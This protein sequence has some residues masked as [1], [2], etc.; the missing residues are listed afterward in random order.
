[1]CSFCRMSSHL[2]A[3]QTRSDLRAIRGPSLR[4]VTGEYDESEYAGLPLNSSIFVISLCR[5][6]FQRPWSKALGQNNAEIAAQLAISVGTV[7]THVSSVLANLAPKKQ[8]AC[9]AGSGQWRRRSRADA[10]LPAEASTGAN[11]SGPSGTSPSGLDRIGHE[12]MVA[13]S[14]EKSTLQAPQA[15]RR[16]SCSSGQPSL[17]RGVKVEPRPRPAMVALRIRKVC[18]PGGQSGKNC[19]T[20]TPAARPGHAERG[21]PPDTRS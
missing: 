18:L 2:R 14:A 13:V 10:A 20:N 6:D 19:D 4:R 1:V 15:R 11:S 17:G 7:E 16:R 3:V 9:D 21:S 8:R 12:S 5:S